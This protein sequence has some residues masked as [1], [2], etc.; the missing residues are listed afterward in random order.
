MKSKNFIKVGLVLGALFIGGNGYGMYTNMQAILRN[1]S[2]SNPG[3]VHVLTHGSVEQKTEVYYAFNLLHVTDVED[4]VS[5]LDV[6][7]GDA[8]LFNTCTDAAEK[9]GVLCSQDTPPPDCQLFSVAAH[10]FTKALESAAMEGASID[11]DHQKLSRFKAWA[12]SVSLAAQFGKKRFKS[13][14]EAND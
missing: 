3:A 4:A 6:T 14:W 12:N 9:L 11:A 2:P 5:R 1:L 10:N 13:M 8:R 7:R